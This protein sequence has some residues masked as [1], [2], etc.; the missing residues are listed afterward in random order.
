MKVKRLTTALVIQRAKPG[1]RFWKQKSVELNLFFTKA[2][3]QRVVRDNVVKSPLIQYKRR[4]NCKQPGSTSK[5]AVLGERNNGEKCDAMKAFLAEMNLALVPMSSI[6]EKGRL[7]SFWKRLFTNRSLSPNQSRERKRF[8]EELARLFSLC[9][10]NWRIES[11]KKSYFRLCNTR[12]ATM[13]NQNIESGAVG[14]EQTQGKDLNDWLPITASRKAKWWY[15]AFHNVTAMVG[16]G[17]LGLPFAFSQLGWGAGFAAIFGSWAITFYS[18]WQLVELHEV[19]PGKRFDRYPELGEHCFGP[20]FGYWFVMPQQMLVQIATDIVYMVT[21]GKSLMKFVELLDHN[22]ENV[23]LTYFILIFACLHLVLSQ[24][25]NFNSL[26]GVSLLAAVMSICYS[27]VAFITSIKKGIHHRPESYGVR[28]HTEVGKAF[29]F[30]NG[31]GTVAFAF[32]GHSVVLEIQATIPSTPEVPSKKPMW[33]GVVIA[34]VIVAF[35]YL[36]VGISGYWAFGQYVEDD[37]LISLRK[38][39][40]LIAIANFMVFFH[41]VGSYQVF[42]MPVFDM[43][44]SYLVQH[45]RFTPGLL[46]RL[47]ARSSYVELYCISVEEVGSAQGKSMLWP[48]GSLDPSFLALCG[49][50]LKS[51][52]GGAFIGL[53]V[54]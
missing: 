1:M 40:W 21:G 39:A 22:V 11:S 18:L 54:G 16:A 53:H 28:S 50:S 7:A 35:C 45:M 38:P 24:T 36:S 48:G 27:M 25:P 31:L 15:S 26:K 19:V 32:A 52:D 49:L 10:P 42:A 44:E 5:E 17:V 51:P 3:E 9:S 47:V 46:L 33:K 23:R 37:V 34:Y 20:R 2:H 12:E 13:V 43:I 30:L 14:I 41:V 4:G 8:S 29:D 6:N